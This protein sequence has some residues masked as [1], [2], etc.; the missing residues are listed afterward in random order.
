MG[1]EENDFVFGSKPTRVFGVTP[2]S[3]YQTIPSGLTAMP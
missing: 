1:V 3:L 2:D